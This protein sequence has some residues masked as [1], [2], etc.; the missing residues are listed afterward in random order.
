MRLA[1][2]L[3]YDGPVKVWADGQRLFHDPQGTNPAVPHARAVKFS[4]ASGAHDLL[5][6]LGTNSG[7]A[8]GIFL[9][10]ERLDV[11][12]ARL[13]KGPGHYAMPQLMPL[14]NT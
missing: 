12:R 9:Q 14:D 2:L 5:V 4:V 1:A 11:S 10:L 7:K 13:R 3:G 8:W 6:A